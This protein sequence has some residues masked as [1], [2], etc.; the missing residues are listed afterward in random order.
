M[1]ATKD[2]S[3]VLFKSHMD[4]SESARQ[5]ASFCKLYALL[6]F[7]T[8]YKDT[9]VNVDLLKKL[10]GGESFEGRSLFADEVTMPYFLPG[11][12]FNGN[13]NLNITDK[14]VRDTFVTFLKKRIL[15]PTKFKKK[16]HEDMRFAKRFLRV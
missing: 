14:T 12:L 8:D 1:V 7:V 4:G 13:H 5:F 9:L 2:A 10:S 6:L 16:E 3:N 11:I 15:V